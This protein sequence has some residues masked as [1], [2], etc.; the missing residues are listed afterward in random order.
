MV[1]LMISQFPSYFI[2]P[3]NKLYSIII[4]ICLFLSFL[5]VFTV[6]TA[7]SST[8]L[9]W[10][11]LI[12]D[13]QN[14]PLTYDHESCEG[15]MDYYTIIIMYWKMEMKMEKKDEE[16]DEEGERWRRRWRRKMRELVSCLGSIERQKPKNP[17]N[18]LSPDF[19]AF[20][21]QTTFVSPGFTL[22]RKSTRNASL[23]ICIELNTNCSSWW[24]WWSCF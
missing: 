18:F 19:T 4:I 10:S 20:S 2:R 15:D 14:F 7:V 12:V 22:S 17:F 13:A 5:Q 16:E 11:K 23:L 3:K 9:I 8:I 6:N 24:W 21:L 1:M